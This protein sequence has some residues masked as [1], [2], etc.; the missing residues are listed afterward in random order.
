ML[1]RILL[2][3]FVLVLVIVWVR[4]MGGGS[5]EKSSPSVDQK[6]DFNKPIKCT[7][8][9][10]QGD[11]GTGEL[12]M[13]INGPMYRYDMVM[14]HKQMGK[15]EMHAIIK[16]GKSYVWGTALS[17]PSFVGGGAFGIIT[18][19]DDTSYTPNMPDLASL[20]T[21]GNMGG[22]KCEPWALDQTM[23]EVPETIKFRD[24]E[25]DGMMGFMGDEMAKGMG[26]L[27]TGVPCSYCERMNTEPM[28]DQCLKTC[29]KDEKK[30]Q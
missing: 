4:S 5:N 2:G 16:D 17:I 24:I 19:A 23:F 12:T 22:M 10:I 27:V 11:A 7:K 30:H 1:K 25:K 13:Y 15:R 28:K 21:S 14:N 18:S 20:K 29:K 3:V 26:G 8:M 9:M 6:V